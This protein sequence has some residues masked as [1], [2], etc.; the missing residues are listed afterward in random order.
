M[1][2]NK[3]KDDNSVRTADTQDTYDTVKNNFLRSIDEIVK[4][5][6][7]YSQSISNLQLDYIQTIKNTIQTAISAQKQL[8]G[9][10]NIQLAAPYTEQFTKQSNEITNNAIRAVAIN[11]ELILNALEAARENLKI[12]NRTVDSVTEFNTNVGKAWT[13][14][15]SVQ[16]QFF[17]H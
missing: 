11:N 5:Q 7:Q 9:G 6:P 10:L 16:Q 3:S 12:Y 1:V 4:V 2:D 8:I 14:L 15:F 13:S 17:R